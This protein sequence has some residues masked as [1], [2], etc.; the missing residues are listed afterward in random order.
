MNLSIIKPGD[1]S[2]NV[3]HIS[4]RKETWKHNL[5][6]L[7]PYTENYKL[8]NTNPTNIGGGELRCFESENQFLLYQ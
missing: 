5:R 4:H 3:R 2:T 6:R 8:S 1:F 7:K